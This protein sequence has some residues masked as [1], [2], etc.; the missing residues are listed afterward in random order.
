MI[1]RWSQPPVLRSLQLPQ[2]NSHLTSSNATYVNILNSKQYSERNYSLDD[3][4]DER[5]FR[6]NFYLIRTFV[7]NFSFSE[8]FSEKFSLLTINLRLSRDISNKIGLWLF[9]LVSKILII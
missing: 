1:L 8:F 7:L 6:L 9:D 4:P 2:H 3:I 5:K